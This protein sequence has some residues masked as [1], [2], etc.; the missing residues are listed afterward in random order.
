MTPLG[1]AHGS[2]LGYWFCH[3]LMVPFPLLLWLGGSQNFTTV[4]ICW[5][6]SAVGFGGVMRFRCPRCG[7]RFTAQSRWVRSPLGRCYHCNFP[8]PPKGR[9]PGAD[10]GFV[11]VEPD[12]VVP[13]W[14]RL[15]GGLTVFII[16]SCGGLLLMKR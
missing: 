3:L 7:E 9:A 12:W 8:G 11:P 10:R 15:A 1:G 2:M 14:L 16:A 5:I 13:F 6:A 4:M